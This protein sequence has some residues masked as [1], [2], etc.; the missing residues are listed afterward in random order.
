MPLVILE[1]PQMG[2]DTRRKLANAIADTVSSILELPKEKVTTL[3][4]ENVPGEESP[5][6]EL[7]GNITGPGRQPEGNR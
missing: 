6:L 4:H 2:D 3:I 1:T 5:G 7:F